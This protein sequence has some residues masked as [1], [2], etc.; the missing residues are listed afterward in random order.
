MKVYKEKIWLQKEL[1]EVNKNLMNCFKWKEVQE[2]LQK[3]EEI[4]NRWNIK[5]DDAIKINRMKNE[6]NKE[7][8][9]SLQ[10]KVNLIRCR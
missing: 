10:H 4:T 7:I 2:Q 8:R 6:N 3:L 9:R 1:E 5:C